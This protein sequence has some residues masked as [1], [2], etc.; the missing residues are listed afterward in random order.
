MWRPRVYYRGFEKHRKWGERRRVGCLPAA[1]WI[2]LPPLFAVSW[3]STSII[4]FHRE[5]THNRHINVTYKQGIG[6]VTNK[7][8][9]IFFSS[10]LFFEM[11]FARTIRMENLPLS[12]FLQF[13]PLTRWIFIQSIILIL[14][15]KKKFQA[16]SRIH[17]V[18]LTRS[19]L[20]EINFR[21]FSSKPRLEAITYRSCFQSRLQGEVGRGGRVDGRKERNNVDF[22]HGSASR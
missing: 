15:I 21:D 2:H 7:K 4:Q 1:S 14:K 19:S 16:F 22:W 11:F 12:M 20:R 17:L 18:S 8:V 6:D 5:Y 13:D 3:K 9:L 10:F